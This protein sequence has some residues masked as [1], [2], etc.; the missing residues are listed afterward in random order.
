MASAARKDI[1]AIRGTVT[2]VR[3]WNQATGFVV[4]SMRAD[5]NNKLVVFCNG[6]VPEPPKVG[7][8]L[9]V[10]GRQDTQSKYPGFQFRITGY[11][12][13]AGIETH[14]LARFLSSFAKFLGDEKAYRIASYFGTNLESVLE[15][16]P[17]RL[18][19]VEGI[20]PTIAQNIADGWRLN[21]SFRSIKVFLMKLGLPDWRIR[22]IVS[23]H[24][25]GYEEKLK[26]DP[27]LLMR[28]GVGFSACDSYAENLGVE[29]NDPVRYRGFIVSHLRST[30][31]GEGHLY[32]TV[33]DLVNAFNKHDLDSSRRKFS[34]DGTIKSELDVH[35][36]RL[37]DDG[38]VVMEENRL[39]FYDQYFFEAAAA[40]RITTIMST[41]GA[42][43]FSAIDL[44]AYIEEYEELERFK[45]PE[46]SLSS[47]QR[48]AL[49]SFVKDKVLVVTG[50]PGTGKTTVVKSFVK[51]MKEQEMKFLLLAPT[52][53]AA[54]RLEE[55][56]GH[57]AYTIHRK[58]GYQGNSWAFNSRN[59]LPVEA[60]LIDE[61]SM[62][63][64]QL[65]F[66]LLDAMRPDTKLVMVGDV[67]QLP[68]VGAGNVLRD[69]IDSKC[70][71][72]IF[73]TKVHR[74]AETSDIIKAA[75]LIK[76]GSTDMSLF[77]SDP[78]ADIVMVGTGKDVLLAQ[79]HI[80]DM[81]RT[82]KN[83]GTT[84]FQ[85]V[86]PR[87]EGD[88][89]VASLNIALQEALNPKKSETETDIM[90][91]KGVKIRTGDRVMI[92]KN[93]YGL[94]VYNG[95]VGKVLSIAPDS[96]RI[97]IEGLENIV[98]VPTREA[99][100]LVKL[101]YAVTVH[102]VQGQEYPVVILAFIKSHGHNLLQ[103]NLLYTALTRAKRKVLV[104]GQEAAV[105]ASIENESIRHRN[106]Q[107]SARIREGVQNIGVKEY[108]HLQ[109][110]L[111]VGDQAENY[112]VIQKML[113]P[114]KSEEKDDTSSYFFE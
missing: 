108:N 2:N 80:V 17:G 78:K 94:G 71:K 86:T 93:H 49:E 56:A 66:R 72:T 101:A 70:I 106:T 19:E 6:V 41:P 24:G 39:Y 81:C 9:E 68:S 60:V 29:H 58:L 33:E 22:N 113:F 47:T 114:T 112:T 79:Q 73:L 26:A 105:V 64:Q 3:H 95:D 12:Q 88:L 84:R 27:Y 102:K 59:K 100:Q 61:F 92:I 38:F 90:L 91:E 110:L 13:T 85:V 1:A 63:D 37:V 96:V 76:D 74:Q 40:Q 34:P 43:K 55:T 46:F 8:S 42:D 32:S 51:M 97:Q 30:V 45:I 20:G 98:A 87:N 89:S 11:E 67:F 25:V 107:L 99:P 65:I 14:T 82:L 18:T 28:E 103:R 52:G 69:L 44:P 23:H 54:K 53:I 7:D 21:R 62:V 10:F 36:N 75:N 57:P 31:V 111:D 15:T 50:A 48:D 83:K 5:R 4:F 16:E 35:I 104:V 77:K 109:R